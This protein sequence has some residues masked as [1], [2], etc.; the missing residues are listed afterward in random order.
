MTGNA[1]MT[2]LSMPGIVFRVALLG[3]AFLTGATARADSLIVVN[4]T[5]DLIDADAD[6]GVCRTSA[7]T[8]S[9]RAAIMQANH[10]LVPGTATIVLPAATYTLTRPINGADGEDNG[11]INLTLPNAAGQAI[12]IDGAGAASTIIDGNQMDRVF[13]IDAGRVAAI[14]GVTIRNGLRIGGNG[15]AILSRGLLVL[16]DCVIEDNGTNGHG[17]GIYNENLL[18][19]FA[20][21]IASNS[22]QLNGGGIYS[23]GTLLIGNSTLQANH[24][25]NVGEG[26][27]ALYLSGPTTLRGSALFVNTANNGA[28]ILNLNQLTVVNSTIDY[29]RADTYGGG[30]FNFGS[31]F[32]YNTSVIGNDADYDDDALG[33]G[34]GVYS[35]GTSGHRFVAVNTLVSSNTVRDSLIPSDCD[36]TLEVYGMNLFG[37]VSACS[38]SGD[39]TNA[40]GL[41]SPGTIDSL[42]DNGGP[43][44][45]NA[46]LAGS[47]AIDSTVDTLGCVDETGAPLTTDQR[48]APRVAG[49]RCDVGAFEYGAIVDLIFTD[50]FE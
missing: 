14:G 30:V 4:T 7:N 37:D 45:T 3:L 32:L 40:I 29:N 9:L 21:T 34:G 25:H 50:G 41:V 35:D 44:S 33:T 18:H 36:G 39:G 16:A 22:A 12:V 43:T 48:G 27:G 46:L 11:D 19:V 28:G 2:H 10:L 24:S 8:C 23:S 20:S 17:G 49:V 42:E 13:S 26:G 5:A 15:G 38:F 1:I 6:D 31:A 47:E